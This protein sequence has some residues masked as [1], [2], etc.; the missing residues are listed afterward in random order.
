MIA[1]RRSPHVLRNRRGLALAIVLILIGL[2][3]ALCQ[4][5]TMLIALQ[6]RQAF[7][8]A[9]QAQVQRLATA[10]LLRGAALRQRDPEWQGADWTPALPGGAKAVVRLSVAS[11]G[12]KTVLNAQAS[13]TNARGRTHQSHQS[14]TIAGGSPP[15]IVEGQGNE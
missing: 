3:A 14:L 12:P 9:D 10:G 11:A 7:Q 8:L 1:F 13:L 15:P 6:H 4:S 5:L 2:F